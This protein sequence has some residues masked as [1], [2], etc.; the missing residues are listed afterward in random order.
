M[1]YGGN[2]GRFYC[3][4][5]SVH[6]LC[7]D[8]AKRKLEDEIREDYL[9]TSQQIPKGVALSGPAVTAGLVVFI[10][11]LAAVTIW[12]IGAGTLWVWILCALAW[13]AYTVLM[14]WLG[15]SQKKREKALV[16]EIDRAKPGFSQFYVAW[17]KK[18]NKEATAVALGIAAAA[19]VGAVA[20]AVGSSQEDDIRRIREKVDRL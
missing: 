16:A 4:I 8:C 20:A 6:G 11:A 18:R 19:V 7:P 10:C 5:H 13:V 3:A 17:K 1:G 12:A 14:A 9:Q 2:C 15:A